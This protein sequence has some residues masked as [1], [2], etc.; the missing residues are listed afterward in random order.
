MV[1]HPC[2]GGVAT[3]CWRFS[4][5]NAKFSLATNNDESLLTSGALWFGSHYLAHYIANSTANLDLTNKVILELGT[6]T[7][8][9]GIALA[10]MD[11]GVS[12]I[13]F[14]DLESQLVT[15][16]ENIELNRELFIRNNVQVA[17][18]PYSFGQSADDFYG[19]LKSKGLDW[20]VDVIVGADI[21]YDVS[22]HDPLYQTL[23]QFLRHPRNPAELAIIAEEMRWKD[24][25]N[26]YF[27]LVTGNNLRLK[28]HEQVAE[29]FSLKFFIE[30]NDSDGE[31]A[32]A[33]KSK[34]F[35]T[36]LE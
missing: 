9:L 36:V 3:Q 20:S 30:S 15:V 8:F 32:T 29:E 22:L 14:T 17:V 35:V 1:G 2:V 19:A 28:L 7:G 23:E 33:T 11:K 31:T 25:Y 21:A 24:I 13:I 16:T 34:I 10:A 18:I 4:G 26:W 6:G 12:K 27:E 5:N